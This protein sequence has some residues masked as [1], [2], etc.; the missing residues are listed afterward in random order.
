[1]S[2]HAVSLVTFVRPQ[3]VEVEGDLGHRMGTERNG[4]TVGY[5]F[6]PLPTSGFS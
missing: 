3:K 6:V 5:D 1:M 4:N 2:L